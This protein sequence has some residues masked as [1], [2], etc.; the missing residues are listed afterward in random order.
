VYILGI[1][2]YHADASAAIVCD[3]RLVAAVEEERF[4][5]IKHCAG[6]PY[7]AVKEIGRVIKSG[8]HTLVQ[9]PN[10]LDARCLYHQARR[11]FR[12]ARGFEVRYW[13]IPSLRSSF[14]LTLA[15]RI[16]KW[17]VFSDSACNIRTYT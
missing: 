6:F 7:Q 1:N 4:N 9:M 2:A 12:E 5:R 16:L 17:I 13:S 10:I 8:G 11:K 3:G 14:P 15:Q